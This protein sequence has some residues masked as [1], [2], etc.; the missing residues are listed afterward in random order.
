LRSTNPLLRFC[1]GLL[2]IYRGLRAIII[3]L[4]FLLLLLLLAAPF[5][6]QPPTPLPADS[7]LILDPVGVIVEQRTLLS[8]IDRVLNE[9]AGADDSGEVLLQDLLDAIKLATEDARISSLVLMTD[10][11]QGGGFSHLRDI[12]DALQRF[13]AAG[14][15]I[16][17]WGGNYNQA[18]YYLA[19]VADTILLNPM[20]AVELEGFGSWQLYF[21]SALDKLGVEAHI[22]RVGEYK[23]AVEPFER[24]DMSP[25]AKSNYSQLLGD[26]WQIYVTDVAQRRGLEPD[27]V[28][29]YIN[30]LD[31]NLAEYGGN[32]ARMAHALG[33][34]DRVESRPASLAWLQENIGSQNGAL[35]SIDFDSYLARAR[36]AATKRPQPLQQI[37]LIVASGEIQDGT[38][39]AGS[40]GGDSLSQLIR[41]AREDERIKA[42]VLRVDSPGGSVFGSE[43]IR[44]ELVAF[45]DSGRPLIVSMGSVAASG[46]Y[47]I[48][49]PADEIWASPATIT[50]SIG[51]FGVL[52]TVEQAFAKLGLQVDGVGTTEL[53]GATALGRP[54]S[55]LLETSLQEVIEHG[56]AS[57]LALVAEARDMSTEDVDRIAQGQVWSGQRALELQ[58]VDR[59]GSLEDALA[60]AARQAGLEAWET[61]LLQQRLPPLQQLLADLIDSAAVRSMLAWAGLQ[62]PLLPGLA[63]TSPSLGD[64]RSLQQLRRQVQQLLPSGD[65]RGAYVH[66]FECS[67]LRLW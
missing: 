31:R 62:Q 66:C 40:I 25:A 43:L 13:K 67:Q 1:G 29:N 28:D 2:S 30:R 26:L 39:A 34:V 27:A 5:I 16:Y 4:L 33:F 20:G 17:A 57:F 44:E 64:A 37:G 58:L 10:N 55:P 7:A 23:S 45:K 52:P 41:E 56:Y 51:I 49:T 6:P 9:T 35:R 32:S 50:G 59:L 18:Q 38:A 47:W 48:A 53:S 46:G 11:L 14:K 61:R 54:L 3:N 24:D 21:R 60:S 12:T 19:S 42:L 65:P 36:T 22:F 63:S 15:R 8:P